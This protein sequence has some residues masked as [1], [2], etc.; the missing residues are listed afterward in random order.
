MSPELSCLWARLSAAETSTTASCFGGDLLAALLRAGWL[1]ENGTIRETSCPSCERGGL[2]VFEE[3]SGSGEREYTAYCGECGVIRLDRGDV[4]A[5]AFEYSAIAAFAAAGIGMRGAPE[6]MEPERLWRLGQTRVAGKPVFAWAA[7]GLHWSGRFH[8]HG[9]PRFGGNATILL[10]DECPVGFCPAQECGPL[11]PL[12]DYVELENGVFRFDAESFRE[13]IPLMADGKPRRP[14][15]RKSRADNTAAIKKY[16]KEELRNIKEIMWQQKADGAGIRPPP[17]PKQKQIAG[18][19]GLSEA[20]VS[21][22]LKSTDDLE[23]RRLWDGLLD[24]ELLAR[25]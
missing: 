8:M 16:L 2:T 10:L 4:A 25:R 15:I 5:Y 19:L 20:A 24:P 23:L 7:R 9:F 6:E 3:P 22:I 1:A 13:A 14:P 11:L 18:M 21:R 17:R 12:K